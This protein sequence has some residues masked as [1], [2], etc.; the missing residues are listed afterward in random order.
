MRATKSIGAGEEI[1]N[2]YGPLPRSDL[3]RMYGYITKNYEKYDVVELEHDLFVEVAGKSD[4]T[5]HPAW[6]KREDQMIELGIADDGYAIQRPAAKQKLEDVI[7]GDIHMI[8]RGLCLD[9]TTTKMPKINTNESISVE[10]AAL[11]S[12]ACTKRLSEY[13]T[14]LDEDH[15]LLKALAKDDP[16]DNPADV[17]L[18]RSTMAVEVRAGEKE[19]LQDLIHLCQ[20]HITTKTYELTNTAKKRGPG[21]GGDTQ[22]PGNAKKTKLKR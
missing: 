5:K 20:D 15:N 16:V 22:L 17:D 19:I 9:E 4:R 3:L 1:F 8:L 6:Q 14:S 2:D 7:P 12:A 13:A 18:K 10:E 21:T 11:L